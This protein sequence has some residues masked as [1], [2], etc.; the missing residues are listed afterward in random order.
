LEIRLFRLTWFTTAFNRKI[1]KWALNRSRFWTAWFNAGVIITIMLLPIAIIV[2][3]KMTFN[4]WLAGSS[5][6]DSSG[7]ILEPMVD[8]INIINI[9]T[10]FKNIFSMKIS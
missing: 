1:I 9:Q 7:V 4:I 10:S 8:Y 6:D 3:L 5:N 2:L